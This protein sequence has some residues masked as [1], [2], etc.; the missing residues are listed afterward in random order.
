[1][2][3]QWISL[4]QHSTVFFSSLFTFAWYV[5][6]WNIDNFRSDACTRSIY[7]A[8][9]EFL[10][11]P[12]RRQK[13]ILSYAKHPLT[14]SYGGM[15]RYIATT[16]S[17]LFFAYKIHSNKGHTAMFGKTKFS[18]LKREQTYSAILGNILN[19]NFLKNA[20]KKKNERR[21]RGFGAV[22]VLGAF[23]QTVQ[24]IY[25]KIIVHSPEGIKFDWSP[26]F[27]LIN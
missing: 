5:I 15:K 18:L 8:K 12:R 24:W 17:K 26:I 13:V 25:C 14:I 4:L 27:R 1:M 6:Q 10:R 9:V 22:M 21:E 7:F 23:N 11:L 16:H 2:Q 20:I 19:N 3:K